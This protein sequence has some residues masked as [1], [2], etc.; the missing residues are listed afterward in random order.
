MAEKKRAYTEGRERVVVSFR[1]VRFLLQVCYDLRFPVFSRNRADY[2]AILYVANWP[3]SRID[4]WDIL[5]RA[6]AIENQCYVLASNRIGSD[7]ACTYP[8]HSQAVDA[9]GR[10][11]AACEEGRGKLCL[12]VS[13]H[14]AVG[15]IQGKISRTV[16][17]R[18]VQLA[19]TTPNNPTP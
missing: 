16:R 1:G 18:Q 2:D 6:R 12:P 3:T 14:G 13:R 15:C 9:Y 4:V 17:R 7:P 10:V 8:G 5:L 19:L 11:A